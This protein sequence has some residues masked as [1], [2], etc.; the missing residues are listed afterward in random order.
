MWTDENTSN[1]DLFWIF[2][3]FFFIFFFWGGGGLFVS[4]CCMHLYFT[5]TAVSYQMFFHWCSF[6]YPTGVSE[7][8]HLTGMGGAALS[9]V[10]PWYSGRATQISRKGQLTSLSYTKFPLGPEPRQAQKNSLVTLSAADVPGVTFV[11]QACVFEF[12]VAL[13]PQR[14]YG[15]W[16]T[17]SPGTWSPGRG[18]RGRGA[19]DVEPGTWSPGRRAR[20]VEPG[21]WSP[22]RGARDV[23]PGTATSTFTQ[24]LCSEGP[25]AAFRPQKQY[26]L[27]GTGEGLDSEWEPRPTSLLT[28]LVSSGVSHDCTHRL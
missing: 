12:S 7:I 5:F 8:N 21:T 9:A 22:G 13:R 17:S 2:C 23:E 24:P 18:A 28:Q 1:I 6:M 11:S 26:G 15:L 20:D 27:L 19:R 3:I 10:V 25:R 14:P 16:G 4:F